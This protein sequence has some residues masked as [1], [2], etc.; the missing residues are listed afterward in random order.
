MAFVAFLTFG[1]IMES[2]IKM[3]LPSIRL[4]PPSWKIRRWL[5]RVVRTITELL[6]IVGLGCLAAGGVYYMIFIRCTL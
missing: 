6:A 3:L 5:R 4:T 2:L 1:G